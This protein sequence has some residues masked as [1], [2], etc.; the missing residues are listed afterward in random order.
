MPTPEPTPQGQT[1]FAK[2]PG[3]ENYEGADRGLISDIAGGLLGGGKQNKQSSG[4]VGQLA[5]SFLGGGH[6]N[7]SSHN[8]AGGLAGQLIGSF[9]SDKPNTDNKP[10]Q[11]QNQGYNPN[12]SH[13]G[14]GNIGGMAASFFGGSHGQSVSQFTYL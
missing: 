7:S 14:H 12:A 2:P 4:L 6:Q 8:S 1:P 3:D 13:G 9:L 5:Q 11:N 10:Q